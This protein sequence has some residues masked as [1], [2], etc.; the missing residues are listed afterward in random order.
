VQGLP[1]YTV[2]DK[3]SSP[4]GTLNMSIDIR[5]TDALNI[6]VP[7]Y[8]G[9]SSQA[10]QGIRFALPPKPAHEFNR[11]FKTSEFIY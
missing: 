9:L 11:S 1:L 5:V 3:D 2:Y 10:V 7:S 4:L 6:L 8:S